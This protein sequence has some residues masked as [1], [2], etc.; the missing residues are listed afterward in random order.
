MVGAPKAK[1]RPKKAVK[2]SDHSARF[3]GRSASGRISILLAESSSTAELCLA[4]G[5]G[6][7]AGDGEC[8]YTT[9]QRDDCVRDVIGEVA[10]PID[11]LSRAKAVN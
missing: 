6:E 2:S 5:P 9:G 8:G 3:Q 11:E 7:A 4:G 1:G 10:K